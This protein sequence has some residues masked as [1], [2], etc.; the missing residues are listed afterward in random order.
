[1][2]PQIYSLMVNLNFQKQRL[3]TKLLFCILFCITT[4]CIATGNVDLNK[5][6]LLAKAE[7]APLVPFK[8][9]GYALNFL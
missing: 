6:Y 9:T 5:I 1:M 2:K 4:I 7:N 8:M 3:N